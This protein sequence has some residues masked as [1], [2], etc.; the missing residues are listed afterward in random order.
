MW[1]GIQLK[2]IY[3]MLD[4]NNVQWKNRNVRILTRIWRLGRERKTLQ[5]WKGWLSTLST[6]G[7]RNAWKTRIRTS[8][9]KKLFLFVWLKLI[10]FKF[11]IPALNLI[12]SWLVAEQLNLRTQ[13]AKIC[14]NWI[15]H[16]LLSNQFMACIPISMRSSLR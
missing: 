16:F 13:K 14:Y 7:L 3:Q 6:F 10:F 9:I 5:I 1:V 15:V 11:S 2:L 12:P 8:N 4:R